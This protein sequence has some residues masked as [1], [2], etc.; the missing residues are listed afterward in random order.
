[1]YPKVMQKINYPRILPCTM[2]G[3]FHKEYKIQIP[4]SDDVSYYG[5][6]SLKTE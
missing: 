2:I 6:G 1:M 3:S 5:G 4:K